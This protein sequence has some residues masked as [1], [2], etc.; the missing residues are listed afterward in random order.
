MNP[1]L[2]KT[3]QFIALGM[4]L[5]AFLSTL[6]A[7]ASEPE[8][9]IPKLPKWELQY[10]TQ[11]KAQAKDTS[12]DSALPIAKRWVAQAE[13]TYGKFDKRCLPSLSYLA[14][15]YLNKQSWEDR[16]AVLEHRLDIWTREVGGWTWD[17]CGIAGQIAECYEEMGNRSMAEQWLQRN[18][19]AAKEKPESD[20]Q[21]I[22]T[23]LE[24]LK[25]HHLFH[26]NVVSALKISNEIAERKKEA[27]EGGDLQSKGEYPMSLLDLARTLRMNEYYQE[28]LAVLSQCD[29]FFDSNYVHAR[30]EW[31]Q[32]R[33]LCLLGSGDKSS[34]LLSARQTVDNNLVRWRQNHFV[35]LPNLRDGS[36][37]RAH[38]NP[39]SIAG[40]LGNAEFVAEQV[41]RFQ[42]A[43]LDVEVAKHAQL[44]TV[45][46]EKGTTSDLWLRLTKAEAQEMQAYISGSPPDQLDK[47][48]PPVAEARGEML[49]LA[50]PHH[51]GLV[52]A[53]QLGAGPGAAWD[54]LLSLSPPQIQNALPA[55]RVIANVLRFAKWS[56]GNQWTDWYGVLLFRGSK[57]AEYI[58]LGKASTID[59]HVMRFR[60]LVADP[61][62][63]N[64][65]SAD[66]A[67]QAT[68]SSLYQLIAAPIEARLIPSEKV[69]FCPA[70]SLNFICP[71]VLLSG[72][73]RFW[74]QDRDVE[75]L[76]DIRATLRSS[77]GRNEKP[78]RTARIFGSPNYHA[79]IKGPMRPLAA[80]AATSQG[81]S[82]A[83]A[84]KN[85]LDNEAREWTNLAILPGT[86]TESDLVAQTLRSAGWKVEAFNGAEATESRLRGSAAPE[87]L[88]I[89]THGLI[90]QSAGSLKST[91][92]IP[93]Y[94]AA[95]S[96]RLVGKM[97][98]RA[99]GS[100]GSRIDPMQST[101]IALTGATT[102]FKAWSERKASWPTTDGVLTAE[103]IAGLDLHGT[104]LVTLSACDT[105]LGYAVYGGAVI[106]LKKALFAAGAENV[107][108]SLWKISDSGTV[109]FMDRF[110]RAY[111]AGK[112]ASAALTVAQRELLTDPNTTFFD[113]VAVYGAF[114]L[115]R[116]T[117]YGAEN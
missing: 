39:I 103:E 51:F 21:K 18:V 15:I 94:S 36:H 85:G 114:V 74:L 23:H 101:C 102:T 80:L 14:S 113:K 97:R 26:G 52:D 69:A 24:Y 7:K 89:A 106:G 22:C 116:G 32:E 58:D 104:S 33:T 48:S 112:P 70:G 31:L 25:Q 73:N 93:T 79:A 6:T 38:G 37:I 50:N 95:S 42:G 111:A 81:S 65:Q 107:L 9:E 46:R 47:L 84:I 16:I 45:L 66:T 2:P 10:E 75:V 19:K 105:G 27:A 108:L 54:L 34:A 20:A 83:Q 44:S 56:G 41:V 90:T 92:P 17:A 43:L 67:I 96:L 71:G 60:A 100:E 88:H 72:S 30:G 86:A 29:E 28:A 87:I 91:Q 110:Y 61:K 35:P 11:T 63:A 117:G 59:E 53:W 99:S 12:L 13:A 115:T 109:T 4:M 5:M 3:S 8:P 49:R 77:S 98:S 40:T 64:G 55:D 78:L 82:L 57:A 1:R 62:P 76:L 68:L